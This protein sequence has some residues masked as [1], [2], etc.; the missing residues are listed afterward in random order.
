MVSPHLSRNIP[1]MPD[2]GFSLDTYLASILLP[3]CLEPVANLS[4]ASKLLKCDFL[5]EKWLLD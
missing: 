3:T 1:D 4:E 2:S 5:M